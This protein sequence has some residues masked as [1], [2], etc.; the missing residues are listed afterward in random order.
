MH[1][2]FFSCSFSRQDKKEEPKICIGCLVSKRNENGKV[3]ENRCKYEQQGMCLQLLLVF[4]Y[5][6]RSLSPYFPSLV[7]SIP[8]NKTKTQSKI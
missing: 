3:K 6:W 8:F 5:L 1:T 4:S 7:N 2:K